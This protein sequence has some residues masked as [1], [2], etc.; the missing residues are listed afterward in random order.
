MLLNEERLNGELKTALQEIKE[1]KSCI[2]QNESGGGW[3][4]YVKGRK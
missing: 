4:H 3:P 1:L 2:P